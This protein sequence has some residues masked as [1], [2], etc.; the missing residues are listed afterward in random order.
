VAEI[1]VRTYDPA[2][3]LSWS[4]PVNGYAAK[5]SIPY[6]VAARV[7]LGSNGLEAYT[8]ETVQDPRLRALAKRITIRE[9]PALT[10]KLPEVR[11]AQ[12]EVKLRSGMMLSET[13][14][15]P[16]GGFDNP[17]TEAELVDKFQRLAGLLLSEKSVVA[18]EILLPRLPELSDLSALS[19][20]LRG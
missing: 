14:E 10:A 9:D 18:L 4:E 17:L 6:N 1:I 12:V 8:E 3:R 15:R 19:H 16:R 11:P 7:V 20:L 13:I 2:T 5:H